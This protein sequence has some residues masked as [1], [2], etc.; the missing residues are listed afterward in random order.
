MFMTGQYLGATY[1]TK[2]QTYVS[3]YSKIMYV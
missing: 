1:Q 3:N 2:I